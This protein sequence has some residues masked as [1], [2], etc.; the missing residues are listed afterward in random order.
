[1]LGDVEPFDNPH[2]LWSDQYE[3]EVQMA[4]RVDATSCRRA[5]TSSGPIVD[6]GAERSQDQVSYVQSDCLLA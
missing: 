2:W 4:V 5:C 1:M 6:G 3:S